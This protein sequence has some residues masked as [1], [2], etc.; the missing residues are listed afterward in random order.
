MDIVQ[1]D[2]RV[3]NA[4]GEN[5]RGFGFKGSSCG[6]GPGGVVGGSTPKREF[7][8]LAGWEKS[9]RCPKGGNLGERMDK[10]LKGENFHHEIYSDPSKKGKREKT[11]CPRAEKI[12]SM[13]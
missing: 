9:W 11:V 1:N 10:G 6:G 12:L 8:G 5:K 3:G 7:A 13:S 2:K 4:R